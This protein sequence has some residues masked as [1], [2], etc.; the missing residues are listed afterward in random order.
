MRNIRTAL[1]NRLGYFVPSTASDYCLACMI[2][3]VTWSWVM[4]GIGLLGALTQPRMVA[5]TLADNRSRPTSAGSVGGLL[6]IRNCAGTE[7]QR[8]DAMLDPPWMSRG[9]PFAG[10]LPRQRRDALVAPARSTG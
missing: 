10:R 6:I 5:P 8:G 9:S 1:R 7:P 4:T 3:C 2:V